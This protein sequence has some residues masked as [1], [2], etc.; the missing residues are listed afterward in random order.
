MSAQP[1]PPPGALSKIK[2][3]VAAIGRSIWFVISLMLYALGT[4]LRIAGSALVRLSGWEQKNN[5][6]RPPSTK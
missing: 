4:T 2:D 1:T 5:D 3:G 6:D